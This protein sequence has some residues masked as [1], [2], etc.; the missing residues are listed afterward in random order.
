MLAGASLHGADVQVHCLAHSRYERPLLRRSP[1]C[2]LAARDFGRGRACV[3]ARA[4]ADTPSLA[5]ADDVTLRGPIAA[6][7]SLLIYGFDINTD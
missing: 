4:L 5:A 6:A 3:E 1:R 2:N 7:T